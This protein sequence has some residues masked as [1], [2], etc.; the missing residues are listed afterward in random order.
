MLPPV[1]GAR[2]IDIVA[3]GSA[4][5]P[6]E[7]SVKSGEAVNIRLV[8]QGATPYGLV[9]PWQRVWL[10]AQPGQSVTSGL[11]TDQPGQYTFFCGAPGN[12]QARTTGL[13]TVTP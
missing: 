8:N 11:R 13:F 1:A 5:Q 4:C 10:F 3:A 7:V 2:T 9:L 12:P 6:A